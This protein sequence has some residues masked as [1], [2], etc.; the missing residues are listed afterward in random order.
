MDSNHSPNTKEQQM[1]MLGQFLHPLKKQR[2]LIIAPHCDDEVLGCG[3][4]ITR[5]LLAKSKVEVYIVTDADKYG[6]GHLRKKESKAALKVLGL[7]SSHLHFL[8]FPDRDR[9]LTKKNPEGKSLADAIKEAKEKHKPTLIFL[10]H[11]KDTHPQHHAVYVQ[12]IEALKGEKILHYL[13][14]YGLFGHPW[15]HGYKP[16]LRIAPPQKINEGTW[17]ILTLDTEKETIK[18]QA[19]RCYTTQLAKR[20]P[21]LRSQLLSFVRTNELF[22]GD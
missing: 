6:I 5:A 21:I 19:I 1:T 16:A 4:L 11:P 14:W 3:G 7:D 20:N 12:G 15:P 13:I 17:S 8:N 9:N 18:E 22:W 10:P 2:I